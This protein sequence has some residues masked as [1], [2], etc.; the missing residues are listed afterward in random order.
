[1]VITCSCV[2]LPS[3]V[4]VIVR[5]CRRL[6]GSEAPTPCNLPTPGRPLSMV[7]VSVVTRVLLIASASSATGSTGDGDGLGASLTAAAGPTFVPGRAHA[8]APTR[9]ATITPASTIRLDLIAT[10]Q[11]ARESKRSHASGPATAPLSRLSGQRA[12]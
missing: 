5:V 10:S 12:G 11:P 3:A 1:M 9:T 8:P 4:I 2:V 7:K 6:A